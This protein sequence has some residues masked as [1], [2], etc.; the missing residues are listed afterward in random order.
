MNIKKGDHIAFRGAFG[1]PNL[2]HHG[3]YVGDNRVVHFSGA[4]NNLKLDA[5]VNIVSLDQFKKLARLR[6]SPL[7]LVL[8]K[9]SL[10]VDER[11]NRCLLLVGNKNYNLFTNNCEHVISECV[12]GKRASQQLDSFFGLVKTVGDLQ[13]IVI[14]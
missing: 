6:G 1:L 14:D 2:Y 10:P 11:V 12:T 13:Y 4:D 8:H 9:K 7:Y 5:S 3:L